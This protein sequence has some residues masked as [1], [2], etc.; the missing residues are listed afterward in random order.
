MFDVYSSCT[1][2]IK[3]IKSNRHLTKASVSSTYRVEHES[4]NS[5]DN[6]ILN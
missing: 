6:D 5:N 1:S 3:S 2:N 4:V